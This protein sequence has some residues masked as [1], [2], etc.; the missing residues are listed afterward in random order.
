MLF[1]SNS[2]LFLLPVTNSWLLTGYKI[3]LPIWIRTRGIYIAIAIDVIFNEL[4]FVLC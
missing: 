3:Q 1:S 2:Y 4:H